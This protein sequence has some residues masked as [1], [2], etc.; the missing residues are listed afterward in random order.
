MGVSFT[1]INAAISVMNDFF[2]SKSM[3]S[4]LIAADAADA[5][6]AGADT[7]G[8]GAGGIA[9]A[10]GT[11]ELL[12]QLSLSFTPL[13]NISIHSTFNSV[14]FRERNLIASVCAFNLFVA[15]HSKLLLL[16]GSEPRTEE[17]YSGLYNSINFALLI[18]LTLSIL[19]PD[20]A[21]LSK[22]SL[23][24]RGAAV[25]VVSGVKFR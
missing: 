9:A 6:A 2:N 15:T 23:R 22:D 20:K 3:G 8:G 25:R 18:T 7:D 19:A 17:S 21:E 12:L 4:I 11:P 24:K 5:D 13:T 1:S 14:S 16:F 10:T